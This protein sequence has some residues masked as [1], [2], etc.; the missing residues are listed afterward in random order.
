M[1][2]RILLPIAIL[3]IAMAVFIALKQ[4]KPEKVTIQKP[5]KSWLV[6]TL[7][8]VI[9]NISPEIILYGR[10]ETPR[11]A[12]LQS[13]MVADIVEASVL[14]GT[15]VSVGQVLVKLDDTDL[16]L[17]LDQ[18]QAD[19]AETKALMA[20]ELFRFQ[21][22]KDLLLYENELLQLA[23]NAVNR[24]TKLEQSH[25]VSQANLD[26]A[27]ATK[28]RQVLTIK[29]LNY[30]IKDHPT[31]LAAL[32][33]KQNRYQA[34]LEQAKVDIERT[35][36]K[37][38]FNGRIAKLEVA[39]GDR[40]M[41][42]EDLLSIYDLESLEVRAQLPGRYLTQIRSSLQHGKTLT[43]TAIV[44][45]KTLD[46]VLTRLSGEIRLDSGGIDGLFSLVGDNQILALGAFVELTLKLSTENAVIAIPFNA[47]YG[48][49]R[50]YRLNDGYLQ[51][52]KVNRVGEYLSE[53]G[54]KQILVRSNE[55][56]AGDALVSTQLPNAITGLRAEAIND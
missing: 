42:G 48:L 28:Q 32:Q 14:E 4:S 41:I 6:N 53:S 27:M 40:V 8:V 54:D 31:R 18:R 36:I 21:R 3:M 20:S 25:L 51:A 7:A 35:I 24:A 50:V 37:A 30:D 33:A 45:G 56:K 26:D 39:L 38:P 19:I 49:N 2:K 23:E 44:D 16:L 5:E 52:V 1:L 47:L 11:Q 55:L 17:I 43:A 15:E 9:Q 13:A 12:M 22:D 34:L 10:V 29:R 46:F